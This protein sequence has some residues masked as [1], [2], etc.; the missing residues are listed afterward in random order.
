[1]IIRKRDDNDHVC[2]KRYILSMWRQYVQREVNFIKCVEKVISKSLWNFGLK[3]IRQFS[4][5]ENKEN[6]MS[7]KLNRFRQKFWKRTC[8][9][10]FSI[11]RSG[12]FA[13][14]TSTMEEI[15]NSTN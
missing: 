15:E 3:K 12:Q 13:M 5:N 7:T 4:R 1:M 9:N 2:Q 10:A 8:G 11:W 14:A 6:I